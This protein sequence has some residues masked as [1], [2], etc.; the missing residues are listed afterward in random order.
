MSIKINLDKIPYEKR[1]QIDKELEVKI[2]NKFCPQPKYIIP[3]KIIDD[4]IIIPFS[5][6]ARQIKIKR[7]NRELFGK[8]EIDFNTSL[9]KEQEVVVSEAT[10]ILSKKGSVIISCYTGFGKTISAIHLACKIKFKTLVIVNKII[11]IKQWEESIKTFCSEDVII[12]NLTAK[13]TKKDADFYIINA[14]NIAKMGND[15][16]NDIGLVIVDEAHLI[17]AET[18]SKSLHY[19]QPRYLLGLTA[20]PYR[21]DGLNSLL[22]FYF[23]EDK[24]IRKLQREHIVYKVETGFKPNIEYTANNKVNWGAILDSQANDEERNELIIEILK[25][26]KDRNFLVLTKR[27][28]QGDYLIE[29]LKQENEKVTSL[30]GS[31]QEFD[32][33]ARIL[34]GT[35]SKI[36][37]G[38]DHKKLDALLLAADVEEYFIQYLGRIF[39][40]K[41]G[42][43]IVVDLVDNNNILI[44]HWLTRRDT[45]IDH[46]GKIKTTLFKK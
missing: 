35:N 37:T 18:L 33:E 2:E 19:I 20:T 38:F 17:M 34:I 44:K 41:E 9:R 24:I 26:F 1:Q 21:P 10:K 3:Y 29:R 15:F 27:I 23:G 22:N 39:R 46:G 32:T 8:I 43:P 12:Q 4:D 30:L 25:Y 45:Y 11:L 40:T 16:F 5:Y 14:Q 7:P 6:A 28:S 42:V 31:N 13:S 36:G